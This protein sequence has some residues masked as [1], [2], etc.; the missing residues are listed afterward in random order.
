MT[1]RSSH[2]TMANHAR[3]GRTQAARPAAGLPVLFVPGYPAGGLGEDETRPAAAVSDQA[4]QRR[5]VAGESAPVA[6][7]LAKR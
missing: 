1:A 2:R 6:H 5:D 7:G 3:R 4:L